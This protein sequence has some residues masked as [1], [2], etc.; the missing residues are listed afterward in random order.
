MIGSGTSG[1]IG[2]T[3]RH[4][5]KSKTHF[6]KG[7]VVFGGTRCVSTGTTRM[8][9]YII[10]NPSILGGGTMSHAFKYGQYCAV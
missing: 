1:T 2:R 7:V 6:V 5:G 4:L 9:D 3:T 8:S 10:L